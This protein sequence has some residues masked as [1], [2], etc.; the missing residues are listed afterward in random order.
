MLSSQPGRRHAL[1]TLSR[2]LDSTPFRLCRSFRAATGTTIHRYLTHV[3][4]QRALGRLAEGAQDLTDLAFE[5][6]FSSHSHFTAVFRRSLGVTP[7][8]VRRSAG[9]RDIASL[10]HRLGSVPSAA[11]I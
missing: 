4:L 7:E 6:G 2:H 8:A 9:I 10:R 11:R 1:D 5:L 3:R